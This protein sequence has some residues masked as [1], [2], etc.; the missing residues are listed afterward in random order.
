VVEPAGSLPESAEPRRIEKNG[1]AI[2]IMA[3]AETAANAPGR[4][5]IQPVQRAQAGDSSV[6]VNRVSRSARR[7]RRR[8]TRPPKKPSSAGS[9]VSAARTVNATAIAAATA[10]P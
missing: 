1:I 6:T 10:T 2:R 7:S 4:F 3:P 5:C 8:G 9:S